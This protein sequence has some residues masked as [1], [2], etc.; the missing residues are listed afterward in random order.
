[1][2]CRV[3]N[4]TVHY[5]EVG[6]GRPLLMLHGW[7]LDHRHMVHDMEPLF[8]KRAGWRRI[9]PD[10]PGMGKTRSADWI[11]HEEHMLDIVIDFIDAVAGAERFAVAGTSYGGYLARGLVYR[12]A[13]QLDGLM[14]N[15]P[16]IVADAAKRNVPQHR[17]L[18]EDAD[19]LAALTPGE[20]EIREIVVAQSTR[21]LEAFRDSIAPAVTVA[22]QEFLKRLGQNYSFTFDVDALA[23]PFPA[24]TLFLTG[25]YDHWCG[26]QDAYRI[27]ENYPRG[28]FVVL[29]RAGH[30]LAVEQ[31][32]LFRALVREWLDRVEEYALSQAHHEQI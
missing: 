6:S 21:A 19:F 9:Y 7:P 30:M 3:R 2:E 14:I 11:T 10:L 22:D 29:D 18:R 31:Q 4:L 20:Q 17:V 25:R 15:V 24:P 12:R 28:T 27:L 13:A 1:M 16:V 8:T 32:T 26:Y 5:E 23:E